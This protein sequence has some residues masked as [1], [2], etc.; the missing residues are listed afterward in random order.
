MP[1]PIKLYVVPASHPCVAV[2]ACLK[3]K[4]LS[5]KRVDL[6]LGVSNVFQRVRFGKRTVPGLTIG[7]RK[8]SGSRQ[9]MRVLEELVP[10]PSLV[11]DDADHCTMADAADEWG[12]F[13]LQEQTRWIILQALLGSPT[14]LNSF[15][16][17]YRAPKL[18]DWLAKRAI[19]GVK[20]EM[21]L[22]DHRS[23][24]VLGTYIP[25]L[26]GHIDHVD[27]LI[28]E[29]IIGDEANPNV[30]DLQIGAS[31]RLLLNIGDLREAIDARPAGALARRLFPDYPGD[32]PPGA[33]RSPF[34][35]L[36]SA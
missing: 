18:P 36:A 8:V 29:G 35:S 14:S 7:N 27:S 20:A 4:G 2:E 33:I 9:I 28:A 16:E 17:G 1:E 19:N 5:Y 11:P 22:L 15:S 30:A 6:P 24:K 25:A 23:D 3:L 26:P 12:D 21:A 10:E 31:L 34:G 32:I 13:V